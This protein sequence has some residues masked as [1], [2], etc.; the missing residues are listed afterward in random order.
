MTFA[1]VTLRRLGNYWTDQGGVNL[2]V[3]GDANHTAGYHLGKDRIYA[4]SGLGGG[5][6]S[7]QLE[8]DKRG[9]SDAASAIDLGRMQGSLSQLYRFSSWLVE[10]CQAGAPGTR[11]VREVIYSPDGKRVQR[12]S[13]VD[14]QIHTGPGNGDASHIGHTHV[15]Y[16]RDSERRDKVAVFAPYFE[17]EDMGLEW[18][19]I[20]PGQGIGTVTIKPDRG[21]VNLRTGKP[22]DPTQ[23]TRQAFGRIRLA[24]PF[25]NA[26]PDRQAGYLVS[27]GAEGHIALDDVVAL[28]TPAGPSTPAAIRS[29]V[30][31]QGADLV[32]TQE[33]PAVG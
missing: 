6:Y 26:G 25:D 12:Y 24:E 16:F 2:G 8:R 19:P 4:P 33:S 10:Q 9:L 3:V 31:V 7:V 23:D 22:I 17:G 18:G 27:V 15:S 32:V 20:D 28:F 1:P 5:D 14:Q 11:D 21:V 29:T 30:T 13:G